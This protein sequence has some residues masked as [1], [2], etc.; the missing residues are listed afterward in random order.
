MIFKHGLAGLTHKSAGGV[1][2][3][4]YNGPSGEVPILILDF[5]N[6]V[7][8]ED[9]GSGLTEVSFADLVTGGTVITFGDSIDRL[10]CNA[11]NSDTPTVDIS[12]LTFSSPLTALIWHTTTLT[13]VSTAFN[14]PFQL[15][16]G[17]ENNRISPWMD[18]S[19]KL[20]VRDTSIT[21]SNFSSGVTVIASPTRVALAL[22]TNDFAISANGDAA[23]E[24]TSTYV[25]PTV[26]TLRMGHQSSGGNKLEGG[27]ERFVLW[28]EQVSDADLSTM[29]TLP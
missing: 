14:R 17:T 23:V 12:G 24:F 21:Q 3:T 1:D 16:D 27:V 13:S 4:A 11:A 15:D 7:Y 20:N 25:V 29:T 22:A 5:H 8:A 26:D 9:V 2:L 10:R 28:D 19:Y 18:T 6:A